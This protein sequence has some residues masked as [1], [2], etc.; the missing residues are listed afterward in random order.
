[1]LL[2]VLL[3]VSYIWLQKQ[4]PLFSTEISKQTICCWTQ[5]F[6]TEI[7]DFGLRLTPLQDLEGSMMGHVPAVVMGAPG[8][9]DQGYFLALKLKEKRDVY[10]LGVVFL[11]LLTSS[12]Q[13]QPAKTQFARSAI[14]LNG[15]QQPT[16]GI[17]HDRQVIP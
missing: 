17:E 5:K 2:W 14:E 7:A 3:D 6:V 13:S 8:Y 11:G 16:V 4:I 12:C 1:M 9:V 15:I 10:S